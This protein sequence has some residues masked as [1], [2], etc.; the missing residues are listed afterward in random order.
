MMRGPRF[1][2]VA[3]RRANGEIVIQQES[4]ESVIGKLKWLNKPFLRGT[5]AMLD[6]IMLGMKALMYSADVAM[7]DAQ[8][9]SPKANAKNKGLD[10]P[11]TT[12]PEKQKQSINDIAIGA[13]VFIGLGLGILIFIAAPQ[14]IVG[15]L[16][17][18]I[19]S[20]T[21]LNL[22]AGVVK[23][24]LFIGYIAAISLM[25]DIR[26]VFEYHG[27]EHKV[28]NTYEAGLELSPEN[29]AKTTTI[30][31]RCGTSFLLVVVVTSIVIFCFLGWQPNVF[32][33]IAQRLLL[34]PVVAGIAYEIIRYAGKHKES[35]LLKAIIAPGLLLQRLTTRKPSDDQVEV[36]LA[37]FK[38]V[39]DKENSLQTESMPQTPTCVSE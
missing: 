4:V 16:Q 5:F 11:Q 2:A 1:Y 13:T 22:T 29:F 32:I 15:L 6:A 20:A 38:A 37:A 14:L 19:Q 23:L 33:R 10:Q 30:H 26:R 28:I 36:A 9:D 39:L 34:L 27:A 24:G 7:E 8:P 35:R 18:R 3:C 21:L 25:K 12:K 31:P 17:K